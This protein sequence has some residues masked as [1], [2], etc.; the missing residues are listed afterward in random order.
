MVMQGQ[1]NASSLLSFV[2]LGEKSSS[3]IL[4]MVDSSCMMGIYSI[5][6]TNM[7]YIYIYIYLFTCED[8]MGDV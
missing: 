4:L 8:I 3:G 2:Q 7:Y 1:M 6:L 5:C